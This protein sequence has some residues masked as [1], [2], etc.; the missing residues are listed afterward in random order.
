MMKS[1]NIFIAVFIFGQRTYAQ[2]TE[3]DTTKFSW[4]LSSNGSWL[5][6][7]VSRLLILSSADLTIIQEP[8]AIRFSNTYQYGTVSGKLTENDL[9]S[10]NFFYLFPR[11]EVYPYLIGWIE[12]NKRRNFSFRYQI[13]PGFSWGFVNNKSSSVKISFTAT[14]E[15]TNYWNSAYSDEKYNGENTIDLLR[16]TVR[17]FGKHKL[18]ENKINIAYEAWGQQAFDDKENK[19]FYGNIVLEFPLTQLLSFRT[20]HN[21]YYES[22]VLSGVKPQDGFLFF[23]ISIGENK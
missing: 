20:G 16:G 5:T 1:L 15:M 3:S 4:K 23:G 19:R 12:T 18:F 14:Y 9:F 10:R 11:N 21:Y 2:L 17:L 7:N 13:G 6:G 8:W 22:L